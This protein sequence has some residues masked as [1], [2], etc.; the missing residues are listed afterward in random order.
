MF[1]L[2]A[3]IILEVVEYASK[4]GLNPAELL[5]YVSAKL[6]EIADIFE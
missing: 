6:D 5:R 3:R 2:A 4:M 1:L